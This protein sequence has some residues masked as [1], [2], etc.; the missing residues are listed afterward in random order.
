MINWI[1]FDPAN[2][3]KVG[4]KYLVTDKFDVDISGYVDPLET[5]AYW[6]VEQTWSDSP[7]VYVAYYAHI[8]M[9]REDKDNEQQVRSE[10][11]ES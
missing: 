6:E 2:T 1:K 7:V 5:G 4:E 9:P 10:K 11:D 8:N 3:P